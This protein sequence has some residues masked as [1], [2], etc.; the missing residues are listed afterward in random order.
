MATVVDLTTQSQVDTSFDNVIIQNL[1]AT[2]PQ[3]VTLDV[4]AYTENVIHAGTVV[5]FD[6]GVYKPIATDDSDA[7]KAVGVVVASVLKKEPIVGVM[8]IGVVNE[9]AYKEATGKEYSDAVKTATPHL[10]FE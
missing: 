1:L 3:G 5:V 8:T 10:K 2:L 7:A 9:K 4:S 6:S